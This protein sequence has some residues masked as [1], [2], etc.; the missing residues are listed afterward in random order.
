MCLVIYSRMFYALIFLVLF[1]FLRLIYMYLTNYEY[2]R[3]LKCARMQIL[4][5]FRGIGIFSYFLRLRSEA[6]FRVKYSCFHPFFFL[7]FFSYFSV[8]YAVR[9]GNENPIYVYHCICTLV[10]I[11]RFFPK[12]IGLIPLISDN[13]G[14]LESNGSQRNEISRGIFC[15]E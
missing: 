10:E 4:Q 7:P 3:H 5:M 12:M 13:S 15:Y 1:F 2:R 9:T 11:V 6:C 14:K 8:H